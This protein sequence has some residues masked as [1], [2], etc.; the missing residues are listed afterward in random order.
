MHKSFQHYRRTF[1]LLNLFT[2]SVLNLF[3]PLV[4]N[5]FT[6]SVFNLFTPSVLNM[7]PSVLNLFTHSVLNLFTPSVLS[8]YTPSV[9]NLITP[10]V[11][12]LFIHSVLSLFTPSVLIL[13]TPSVL[14][15]FIPSVTVDPPT[16]VLFPAVVADRELSLD[17][18]TLEPVMRCRFTEPVAS[19]LYNVQWSINN[20]TLSNASFTMIE[21]NNLDRLACLRPDHWT[22]TFSMNM[23]VILLR[24][25]VK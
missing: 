5:L 1:S 23:R 25:D 22:R 18:S 13:F 16:D 14:N 9:L 12:C 8:L 6:P 24:G 2:P 10:S 11:L 20:N 17:G 4:L 21:Y 15:L 7:S 19:L 3:T